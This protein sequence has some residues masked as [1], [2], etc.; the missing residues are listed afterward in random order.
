MCIRDSPR[1]KRRIISYGINEPADY[2][3][4]DI[5]LA[6]HGSSYDLYHKGRKLGRVRLNVPGLFNVYNSMATAAVARE[7]DMDFEN[8]REGMLEFCGVQRRLEIK[9]KSNGITVV[10]DYGHHPTEVK[11]TLAAA[12]QVWKDRL[13]VIFQ[14]HRYTRTRALFPEFVTCFSDADTLIL[15]DIYAASE[16]PIEGVHSFRLYE[17]IRRQGHPDVRYYPDFGQ[18]V[19]RL[20][21]IARPNDIIITQGA[22]TVW[23]IGEEFLK[24]AT[25]KGKG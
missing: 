20:L 7:L 16:K 25:A 22:G 13:I 5:D 4:V 14:P 3:A 24:K 12:R 18:I 23:K 11:A 19:D 10:D 6:G 15:T 8:I 21:E 1:I 17:E 2:Q 9:G